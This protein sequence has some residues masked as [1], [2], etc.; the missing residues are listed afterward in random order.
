[1]ISNKDYHWYAIYTKSRQEKKVFKEIQ[2]LGL[3]AY[4]PL[5]TKIVQWSDRKKKVEEPMI[6]SYVFVKASEKEYYDVL[7][8]NGIVRY[9]TFEGK[10][11]AIPEWQIEA[12]KKMLENNIPHAYSGER[13]MSGEKILIESGPLKGYTGE[14]IKDSDGKKKLV[15][16]IENIGYS[17]ILEDSSFTKIKT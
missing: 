1:M 8:I 13:F 17:L 6:R 10:A 7:N 2:K 3:T 9:V 14:I 5:E 11:A 16:R 4:M 12:M 15:I